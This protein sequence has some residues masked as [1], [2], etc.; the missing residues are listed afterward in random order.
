[1]GRAEYSF[2]FIFVYIESL[3]AH[4]KGSHAKILGS[5]R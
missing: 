4:H 2:S 5:S 3:F 1:M